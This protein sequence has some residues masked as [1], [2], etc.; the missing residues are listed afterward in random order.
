MTIRKQMQKA[1]EMPSIRGMETDNFFVGECLCRTQPTFRDESIARV[2]ATEVFRSANHAGV[3]MTIE[4]INT[5]EKWER[6][7]L[8][9]ENLEVP[10]R[11]MMSR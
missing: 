6:I 9:L 5:Q 11:T 2:R 8:S 10:I 4:D 7:L 3:S 1:K